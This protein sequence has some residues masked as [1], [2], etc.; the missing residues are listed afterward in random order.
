MV[1]LLWNVVLCNGSG[2]Y[3][4]TLCVSAVSAVARC[5]SPSVLTFV[6]CIQTAEDIVKLLCRPGSPIILVFWPQRR[7]QIPKKTASAGRKIQGVGKF[8]DFLLKSPYILET[9]DVR[10]RPEF[11]MK[12]TLI[13]SHMRSIK[14]WHFEWPWRTPNPVFKVTAHLKSN[15]SKLG[16]KLLYTV[17]QKNTCH[18]YFYDN[19]GKRGPI[20]IIFHC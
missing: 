11:A 4:A 16:T 3:R 8:C 6:H 12:H 5:L 7:Y 1:K 15:I 19:F 20:F 13:G 18:F 10:D 2:F 17:S 14:W 9:H